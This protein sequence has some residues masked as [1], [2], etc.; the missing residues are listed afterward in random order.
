MTTIIIMIN[1]L[2][3]QTGK[4]KT[5]WRTPGIHQLGRIS[6]G[7]WRDNVNNSPKH[8]YSFGQCC[9]VLCTSVSHD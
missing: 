2:T 9:I 8:G 6:A 7:D 5:T 3:Q 4:V 1:K